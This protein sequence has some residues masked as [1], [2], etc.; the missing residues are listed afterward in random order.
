M[1]N[2][3]ITRIRKRNVPIWE[4]SLLT[5]LEASDYTGI[6]INKPRRN[7]PRRIPCISPDQSNLVIYVGSKKMFKRKKLDE[8]LDRTAS[9]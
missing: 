2:K 1:E 7:S 6:G 5:I 3:V 8:Y 4:R 9:V